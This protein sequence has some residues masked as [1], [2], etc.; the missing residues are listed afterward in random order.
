MALYINKVFNVCGAWEKVSNLEH[1]SFSELSSA[2]G[3]LDEH[4][5]LSSKNSDAKEEVGNSL[6]EKGWTSKTLLAGGPLNLQKFRG[7]PR[8][9]PFFYTKMVLE[10][11]GLFITHRILIAGLLIKLRSHRA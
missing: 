4:W 3:E 5:Y 11:I 2:F 1:Q 7:T 9:L 10:L 6:R 8:S